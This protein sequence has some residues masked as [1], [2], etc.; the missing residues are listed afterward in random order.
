[1][2]A[3]FKNAMIFG[4]LGPLWCPPVLWLRIELA[5][6]KIEPFTS[7]LCA[8]WHLAIFC[9]RGS[10]RKKKAEN[11]WFSLRL[12]MGR[13]G[14]KC[15]FKSTLVFESFDCRSTAKIRACLLVSFKNWKWLNGRRRR[16]LMLFKVQ[17]VLHVRQTTANYC[18]FLRSAK[19]PCK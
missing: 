2:H 7:N 13:K 14:T 12:I 9:V 15:S 18:M 3:M 6:L 16:Y 4:I 17:Y 1:M 8:F 19:K 5:E 10:V 11:V